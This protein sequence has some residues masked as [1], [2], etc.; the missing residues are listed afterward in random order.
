MGVDGKVQGTKSSQFRIGEASI[1]EDQDS[2]G[3]TGVSAG[4]ILQDGAG[5]PHASFNFDSNR[6]EWIRYSIY[7]M[8]LLLS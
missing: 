4:L 7:A 6:G 5:D 8:C 3:D 2:W 1:Y